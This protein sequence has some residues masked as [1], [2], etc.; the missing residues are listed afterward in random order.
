MAARVG[1]FWCLG[2]QIIGDAV[3]L[4][5]AEPYGDALQHGAHHDFWRGLKGRS[6]AERLFKGHAYDYYPRGRV[7]FFRSRQQ[8]RLY[9]DSCLSA[10]E[11]AAVMSYFGLDGTACE[12]ERDA[13]YQ[14]AQCNRMF[15]DE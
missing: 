10:G 6:D 8:F 4:S 11:Q 7:V 3:L 13:H 5:A 14:C 12:I 9:V 1:I 2:Q 15:V